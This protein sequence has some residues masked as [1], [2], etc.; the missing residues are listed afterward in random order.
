M[1]PADG[2]ASTITGALDRA[3][4]SEPPPAL[5]ELEEWFIEIDSSRLMLP[6]RSPLS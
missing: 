4:F 6:H 5:Q 3:E 1:H 2:P